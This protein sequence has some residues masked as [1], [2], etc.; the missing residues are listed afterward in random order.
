MLGLLVLPLIPLRGDGDG[1]SATEC[2]RRKNMRRFLDRNIQLVSDPLL[3]SSRVA[4]HVWRTVPEV[5]PLLLLLGRRGVR[6]RRKRCVCARDGDSRVLLL[7]RRRIDVVVVTFLEAWGDRREGWRYC[8]CAGRGIEAVLIHFWRCAGD[9]DGGCLQAEGLGLDNLADLGVLDLAVVL[10]G[11][12]HAIGINVVWVAGWWAPAARAGRKRA[13]AGRVGGGLRTQL[14]K[15]KVRTGSVALGHGLPQLL[16]GPEAV[17]DNAVDDDAKDFDNDFDD[18][19]DKAPV[20]DTV[21]WN[22]TFEI[23][24]TYLKT[25]DE[26]VRDIFLKQVP[27][28]VVYTR[29]TPHVLVVILCFTLVEDC[30]SHSPH[31]DAENEESNGEDGIVCGDLFGSMVATSTI[32]DHDNDRHDKRYASNDKE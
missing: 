18:G 21:R 14:G 29:P 27:A 3:R 20:L 25:A 28:L 9:L 4:R 30:C 23:L 15:V 22:Y 24:E 10:V 6:R 11:N 17:E 12:R 2:Q 31:D 7:A 32:S 5:K 8:L 1:T 26:C 13:K 19:A 16:L